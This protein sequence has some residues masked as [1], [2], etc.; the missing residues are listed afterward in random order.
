MHNK[1]KLM[2]KTK[3]ID[4]FYNQLKRLLAQT[5]VPRIM[6]SEISR[7]VKII[8]FILLSET[9]KQSCEFMSVSKKLL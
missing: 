4:F 3:S 9:T 8:S 2:I 5:K 7:N 6:G 1:T